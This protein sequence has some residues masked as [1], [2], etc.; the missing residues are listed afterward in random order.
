MKKNLLPLI[1]GLLLG[2]IPTAM[3]AQCPDSLV[4]NGGFEDGLTEWWNWHGGDSAAY[5]F[6]V[7]DDAY[8]GDSSAMIDV[9]KSTGDI[10][11][12]A[13][14][15][16]NRSQTIPVVGGTYYRYSAVLKSTVPNTSVRLNVKDEN[17]SWFTLL[18]ESVT[19]DTVWTPVS[20]LFQADVD[21][22]DVHME[23]AVYND[24]FDPYTVWIDDVD[25]CSENITTL[26]CA[27]NLLQNP[28]FED[29]LTDAWGNWHG[30]DATDYLFSTSS[31]SYLGD[32]AAMISV[33]KSSDMVTGAGEINSRPGVSAIVDSQNYKITLFGKSTEP[34]TEIVLWVKDE[35][36][37][38]TT[39]HTEA[40]VL[41]TAWTE[42][43]S[44]FTADADRADV[45]LEIK[46]F[47]A[48]FTAPYSVLIDEVSICTTDEEPG[49]GGNEP[50]P[51]P[52]YGSLDATADCPTNLL[53]GNDGFE[54][55]NNETGWDIWDGSDTEEL[56]TITLDPVLPHTGT[57]SLRADVTADHNTAEVH[58]RFSDRFTVEDGKDYTLTM[59]IRSDVPAGDTL[60]VW[61]RVVRDTD[62][63][64]Q[65]FVD[66][67]VLSNDWLN[68]Q[69][70]FTSDGTWNNAFVEMKAWRWNADFTEAYSVWYDD[71]QI[72]EKTDAIFTSIQDLEQLGLSFRMYPNPVHS[73]E[74]A[75]L[76]VFSPEYLNAADITLRDV[77]GRTIWSSTT[78]LMPGYL[79]IEVPT[80]TLSAGMYII[81]ISH[82]GLSKNLRLQV[83]N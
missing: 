75:V 22:A 70:T 78:D 48:G 80:S 50:G 2:I 17:D 82:Q 1:C 13:G 66:F 68:F 28:G 36:D 9:L 67:F 81:S 24:G 8:S 52:V 49:G 71:V 64:T 61:A 15:Y 20:I 54:A 23:I 62:W 55:P 10:A 73:S 74:V 30:G 27:D 42:V 38:W 56:A 18:T 65:T 31:D 77:M 4:T 39:I 35:F 79:D 14:E 60:Q 5:S 11:G 16:N 7:S 57:N 83:T 44:V 46:V 37:G 6:E 12:G 69:H 3:D 45:H 43:S 19:V 53:P 72:C 59:W 32:S 34:N 29:G 21:R 63:E 76:E 58:H 47:N 25:L 41:D 26:T 40:V 33:L 51:E